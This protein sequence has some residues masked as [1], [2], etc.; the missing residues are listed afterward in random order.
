M[1][2][3]VN[4]V[5][6]ATYTTSANLTSTS[7]LIGW[8]YA[9]SNAGYQWP[10]YISNL[11][12]V[13]GTAVYTSAFTPPTAPLTAITNTSLLACQSNRFID[14]S[15][16]NFAITRNGDVSVQRFSPFNPTAAYS[17]S[18]I[19]GSG[20]FDGS[21][22]WLS[23]PDNTALKMGSSNFTYECWLYP[24][25]IPNT[26]QSFIE[27]R[28][29]GAYGGV[30]LALKSNGKYSI[31]IA[32]SSSTWGIVDETSI[33]VTLNQW[34][35]L[36]FVR[37]GS[38]FYGY[39]NGV[40]LIN[41]T[42]GFSVYDDTSVQGIGV[43]SSS[44]DQPYFGYIS[45]VRIVKGA[46]VYTASSFTPP[47]APLTAITNTSLLTNF[48]N[49]GIFD[50]AMMNNLETVGNAQ[51]ST[52]VVKFGTGSMLF[53][54]TT[55]VLRGPA[56]LP[57][58]QLRSGDFTVECWLYQTATNSFPGVLEIGNHLNSSGIV[59]IASN[60]SIITAYSGTFLGS[61]TAPAFNTWNHIAWVRNN[62]SFKIY[63]NGVGNSGVSFTNNLNDSST[64]TIGSIAS[65]SSNYMY[66]GYIDDLRITK[67]YARYTSNF[68]PPTAAFQNN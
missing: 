39:L 18:T 50:N 12:A 42:I 47:T 30:L 61:A 2:L 44:A 5:V 40:R 19:G 3:F 34:Q 37:S 32:D 57:T 28:A 68:T 48:T 66:S 26:Y 16:N 27:K 53:N 9:L 58:A 49:G 52:S 25:S 29:A 22:D 59:F 33:S 23:V 11:R 4:G 8:Y 45:D 56:N 17:T 15:T 13:K 41:T 43:G 31:L 6:G 60:S 51:I 62:G 10:G 55:D 35:H 67:G 20:Y 21:G 7:N 64:L 54:G 24:T 63:V 14:N 1:R 46:A 36:A 65:L 38:S